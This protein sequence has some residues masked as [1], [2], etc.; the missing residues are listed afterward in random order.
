MLVTMKLKSS[1]DSWVARLQEL[2]ELIPL[3]M[4]NCLLYYTRHNYLMHILSE[5]QTILMIESPTVDF[6]I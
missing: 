1:A 3:R 5:R 6:N 4:Y 2:E